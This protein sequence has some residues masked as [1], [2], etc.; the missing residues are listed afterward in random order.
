MLSRSIPFHALRVVLADSFNSSAAGFI[1]ECR[2]PGPEFETAIK[3]PVE[4]E[5]PSHPRAHKDPEPVACPLGRP[6][7]KLP[8]GAQFDV[9]FEVTGPGPVGGKVGGDV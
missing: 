8:V 4:N 2:P 9:V 1:I 5:P 6:V 7:G 3:F